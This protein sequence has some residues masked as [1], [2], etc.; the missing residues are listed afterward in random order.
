VKVLVIDD[1]EDITSMF[2]KFLKAKG[3][4]TVVTNDPMEG[5]AYSTRT[6]WC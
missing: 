2:S 4:E 3:C 5:Q 1:N 6:V